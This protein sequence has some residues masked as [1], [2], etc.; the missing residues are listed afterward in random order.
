MNLDSII[1]VLS[2]LGLVQAIFLCAY[3]FTFKNGNNKTNIYLAF[4]LLGLTIRIGKSVLNVYLTLEPW[5]RNL[6]ISGL[7]L[8]GPVLWFYGRLLLKKEG[9]I[10]AKDYIHLIPFVGFFVFSYFIPNDGTALSYWIYIAVFI[11][12]LVYLILSILIYNHHKSKTDVT[13]KIV[14]RNLLIGTGLIW[15]FY[16]GNLAGIF[17][18]YIGGAIFFSLLVYVFS[19]L[20]LKKPLFAVEKYANSSMDKVTSKKHIIQLKTLLKNE[21]LYLD[22]MINLEQIAEKM[23]ISPRNLSQVINENE[24][25]NFSEFVNEYRIERAKALLID[26]KYAQEKI[27]TI[28]YDCGFGNV[29]SFNLAFKSA[30]KLTPSQYRKQNK[31]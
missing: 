24:Q 20:L 31:S 10:F 16:M 21:Q 5:Q 4:F 22:N 1:L 17:P 14:Y 18:F 19:F 27:A 8:S 9:R 3:L 25:K 15:V 2:C 7:L 11:H 12:L 6:G 30:T 28:A 23:K 13:I 26:S 29:T